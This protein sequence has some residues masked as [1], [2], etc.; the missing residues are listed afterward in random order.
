MIYGRES[1]VVYPPVD[2]G[3][4]NPS[5][6]GERL[7]VVSRLLPF[8]RVDLVVQAATR[9]SIPLDVVGLGPALPELR[10]LAGPTVTFHGGVDDRTLIELMES[11]RAV[12]VAS[13][14]DFGIVAVEANAAGKPAVALGVGGALETMVDGE[15]GALYSE[16]SVEGMLD[17]IRRADALATSPE[18]LAANAARFSNDVF[19]DRLSSVLS[20]L[21]AQTGSR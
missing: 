4:F 6:R 10:A 15:T 21:L 1:E 11:C 12:C 18:Q 16:Q 2:V 3:R 17:A 20:G 7:L 13:P 5:E 14:E 8:K 19:A 9:A